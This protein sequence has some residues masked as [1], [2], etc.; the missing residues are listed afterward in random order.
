MAGAVGKL[1]VAVSMDG[2]LPEFIKA[3]GKL[4]ESQA[5]IEA[6]LDALCEAMADE[7]AEGDDQPMTTLDGR[8]VRATGTAGDPM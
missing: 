2:L 6:K 5:R 3:L 8:T 1:K 7:D 4:A